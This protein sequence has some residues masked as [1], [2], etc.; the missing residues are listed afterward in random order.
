[1]K[2]IV[3]NVP[4]PKKVVVVKKGGAPCAGCGKTI[5]KGK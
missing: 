4:S 2:T 5:K 1:M 3:K